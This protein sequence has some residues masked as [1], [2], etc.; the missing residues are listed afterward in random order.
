MLAFLCALAMVAALLPAAVFAAEA[1]DAA[2]APEAAEVAEATEAAEAAEVSE[3][4]EATEVTEDAEDAQIEPLASIEAT[5]LPIATADDLIAFAARVNAGETTLSAELV[6]DI[7]VSGTDFVPIG[8]SSSTSYQGT[9]DGNGHTLTVAISNTSNNYFAPFR[10]VGASGVIKNLTVAGSVSGLASVAGVVSMLSGGHLENVRNEASVSSTGPYIGGLVAQLQSG[11]YLTDCVNA[12]SVTSTNGYYAG[13]VIGYYNSAGVSSGLV[14]S[15]SVTANSNT[16]SNTY[17]GAGGITSVMTISGGRIESSVNTGQVTGNIR[18]IGGIAGVL[19]SPGA[20]I[21][22]CYNTGAVTPTATTSLVGAGGIVG[23]FTGQSNTYVHNCTVKNCY[24]IGTVSIPDGLLEGSRGR[25][26]GVLGQ[27]SNTNETTN[28]E[29]NYY[30]DSSVSELNTNT[31]AT[32]KTA[33]EMQAGGFVLLLNGEEG[34]AYNVDTDGINGGYPVL[35]WQGGTPPA[36]EPPGDPATSWYNTE[37]TSFTL[38]DGIQLAG[39]AAIVNGTAEGIEQDDF[40]GKTVTLGANIVLDEDG[41]YDSATGVFGS[42]SYPV[43]FPYYT[44]REG[45]KL[46][47]PIG[48]GTATANNTFTQTNFFAGTFDGA[49]HSVSGLYTDV[50]QTT[51]GLFGCVSG[52]VKNVKVESGLVS[53]K[54]VAGGVVAYLYGGTVENCENHAIVYADG[55]EKAASGLENGVSRGGAIGGIVGNAYGTEGDP[56]VITGCANTGDILNTNTAKGGRTGGILGLVDVASYVGEITNNENSGDIIGYQ[57]SGGIVG[58]DYSKY[59]PISGCFN[60][61]DVR[62]SASGSAYGGGIV[63]QCYSNVTGCYNTGNYIGYLETADK[64]AH[65]GGI[66]SDLFSPALVTNCYNTGHLELQGTAVTASSTGRIVGSGGGKHSTAAANILNCYYLEITST[67]PQFADVEQ[68][69]LADDAGKTA[70]EL[71][72]NAFVLLLNGEGDAFNLDTDGINGGYPVLAWQ[73]GTPPTPAPEYGEPG[74]GDLNGD[75]QVTMA[76]VTQLVQAILGAGA[77]TDGQVLAADMDGDGV[78]T[79]ADVVLVLHTLLGV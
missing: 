78:L 13:G 35:A 73:G 10:Y 41:L 76:E 44:L 24:N 51:Q 5:S 14:N 71:K 65:L 77:L 59:A 46:W 37:D 33:E 64:S 6:A 9:F 48:T 34:S 79:M 38:T 50:S 61:G 26:G 57:Y 30:L 25:V 49:G 58:M 66:V 21:V 4:A 7:D 15:G 8:G 40:A 32:A 75:G 39:L 69:W 56:F 43:T 62:I 47:T 11:G 67:V 28:F 12:G 19:Y 17:Y 1:G 27:V 68:G 18:N 3:V 16:S 22:D 54:I 52:T 36:E 55:G 63:S 29:N 60:S 45:A 53:A 70:D 2:A 31:R 23:A 20:A 72:S 42:L 74:S